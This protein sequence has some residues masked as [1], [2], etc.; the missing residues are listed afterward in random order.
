MAILANQNCVHLTCSCRNDPP[1]DTHPSQKLIIIQ[2]T[3][4]AAP[5]PPPLHHHHQYAFRE[6]Q[7]LP[8]AGPDAEQCLQ[9]GRTVASQ[10]Y[11]PATSTSMPPFMYEQGRGARAAP[12]R[13]TP[14]PHI[15]SYHHHREAFRKHPP[16]PPQEPNTERCLTG[17]CYSLYQQEPIRSAASRGPATPSTSRSQYGALPHGACYSLYQQEPIWSAASRGPATAP[18]SRSQYGALPHGVQLRA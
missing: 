2:H 11:A 16:T 3:Y 9:G 6:N 14:P 4:T 8:P 1:P 12:T 13:P 10:G 18:T 15:L 7:S 17:A 5:P